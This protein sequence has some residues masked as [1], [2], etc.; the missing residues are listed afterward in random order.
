MET[1]NLGDKLQITEF[2][3]ASYP[4]W[5]ESIKDKDVI[6]KTAK[7]KIVWAEH[8]SKEDKSVYQAIYG[9]QKEYPL[10]ELAVQIDNDTFIVSQLGFQ[11]IKD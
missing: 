9:V 1:Y 6:V 2:Y 7:S 8:L 4:N 10:W 3:Q 5:A 11:K